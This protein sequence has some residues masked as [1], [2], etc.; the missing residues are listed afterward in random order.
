MTNTLHPPQAEYTPPVPEPAESNGISRTV[1]IIGALV[2]AGIVATSVAWAG[3]GAGRNG[4]HEQVTL[5][6]AVTSVDDVQID[7]SS[8][9]VNVVFRDVSEAEL[10]VQNT[11]DPDGW[12]LEH[13]GD[14][15]KVSDNAGWSGFNGWFPR[16]NQTIATLTLPISLEGK[17]DGDFDVS[18]GSLT[19]QGDFAKLDIELAAGELMYEG[20]A[21]DVSVDV[22]AGDATLN[23]AEADNI[24]AKIAA[25]SLDINLTGSPAQSVKAE[26]TAGGF[27]LAVPQGSYRISGDATFGDR[28]I[29]VQTDSTSKYVI[30]LDVTAGDA[31]VKYF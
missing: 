13:D 23:L 15:L 1:S 21:T 2:A 4:G 20:A 26:V 27:T 25:G 28:T 18:A 14:S 11:S 19:I 6:S 17:I 12:K 31:T 10:T 8:G 24:E 22:S 7:I 29:D 16:D 3:F 30:E 9:E 5:H